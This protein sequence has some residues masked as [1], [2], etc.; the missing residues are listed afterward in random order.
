MPKDLIH[1]KIAEDTAARLDDTR[2]GPLLRGNTPGLLLGSVF[3]DVLF[4]A[5]TR[6]ARP[7]AG[8]ADQLHGAD[9]RDTYA[10]IRLQ[11]AHAAGADDRG[12]AAA[13]LTGMASHLFADAVMHPM[14]WHLSGDYYADRPE[15]KTLARQRHRALESLMD[16][17]FCPHYLGRPL[18][19]LPRLLRSAG[20]GLY[21]ALPVGPLAE[22]AGTAPGKAET[23]LRAAW[24]VH[25][26]FQAAYAVTPLARL[27]FA[28]MPRLPASAKEVA[29]LFYAPQLMAQADRLRGDVDFRHPVT[30]ETESAAI[31][32]MMDT[33]ARRAADL[34]RRLE[35]A[36]DGE[37]IDL[38]E[39]G[40][41]MDAGISSTP[42]GAMT[43]FARV[44]FPQLP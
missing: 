26:G 23:G 29:A 12:L 31:P 41:S 20:A 24:R 36:L 2:F 17:V 39:D 4:Y 44:P 5:V 28:L 35:P 14:V 37:S 21:R 30:G 9:G 3:H 19:S 43:H 15:A 42:A 18:Y 1:F 33:A 22:M 32:D 6:T 13:L 8:L 11:A 25:A 38:P 34:C 7:L 27:A 16:M 10:L 40:P